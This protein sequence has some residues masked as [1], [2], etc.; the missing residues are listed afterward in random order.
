MACYFLEVFSSLRKEYFLKVKF[1]F[2]HIILQRGSNSPDKTEQKSCPGN[3]NVVRR[4]PT[5]S[6]EFQGHFFAVGKTIFVC[7]CYNPRQYT[8]IEGP[9]TGNYSSF[10]S[11]KSLVSMQL[12][13]WAF[14]TQFL[15]R[16]D[17]HRYLSLNQIG[18]LSFTSKNT[19]QS[20]KK[21]ELSFWVQFPSSE[22]HCF[23]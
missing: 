6:G 20:T 22:V 11:L 16:K 13:L 9:L 3:S 5:M 7:W 17:S 18:Y 14:V 21:S 15:M 8:T 4:I 12:L 2:N 19:D 10:Q 23:G 1:L